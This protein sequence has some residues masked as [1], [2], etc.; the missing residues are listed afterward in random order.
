MCWFEGG[1]SMSGGAPA[2]VRGLSLLPGSLSVH[3]DGESERLPVFRSAIA[4]G[5]LP[6]GYAAGDGAALL[7]SGIEL[8]ECVA[9]HPDARVLRIASDGHG[10]VS[11]VEMPVRLLATPEPREPQLADAFGVGELRALRARSSR[12]G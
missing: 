4:A 5:I 3:L 7:Y 2:A 9:S 12:W 8:S 1:I 11:E 6:S 10:G